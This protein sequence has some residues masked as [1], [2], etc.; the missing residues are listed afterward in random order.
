VSGSVL[1]S[2]QNYKRE[3]KEA[4]WRVCSLLGS[5]DPAGVD[6]EPQIRNYAWVCGKSHG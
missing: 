2:Q 3:R 1:E 5:V 4:E 6:R